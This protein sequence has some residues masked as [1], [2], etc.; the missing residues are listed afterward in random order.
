MKFP[1]ESAKNQQA[2]CLEYDMAFT[3]SEAIIDE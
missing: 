2:K 3:Q 1:F